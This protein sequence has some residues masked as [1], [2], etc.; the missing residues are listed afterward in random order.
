MQDYNTIREEFAKRRL[1]NHEATQSG[2]A[3][4]EWPCCPLA[5]L[6]AVHQ[7]V[8]SQHACHHGLTNRD[9]TYTDAGIMA[10]FG[11]NISVV[12]ITVHRLARRRIADVGLTAKQATIDCPVEMPPRIPRRG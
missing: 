10:A 3:L 7:I 8:V 6:A 11:D 12:A 5:D 4:L 1:P 2:T 9:R